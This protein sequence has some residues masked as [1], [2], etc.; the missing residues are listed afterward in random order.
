[1]SSRNVAITSSKATLR[2]SSP[3]NT[4]PDGRRILSASTDGTVRLWDPFGEKELKR[5]RVAGDDS[6]LRALSWSEDG[7][8]FLVGSDGLDARMSLYN[9]EPGEELRSYET[10]KHPTKAVLLMDNATRAVSAGNSMLHVWDAK[11]EKEVRKFGAGVE[12]AAFT[13]D[14]RLALT[15]NADHSVSVWD[16]EQKSSL[17]Q[18]TGHTA[19][20][21]SLAISA[22]G[23]LG[24]SADEEGSIRLW[25]LP[26]AAGLVHVFEAHR[27]GIQSVAFAPDGI[28]A[29]SAGL[30]AVAQIMRIDE[31]ELGPSLSLQDRISSICFSADSRGVLYGTDQAKSQSNRIAVRMIDGGS[32]AVLDRDV[33]TFRGMK[34][35]VSCAVYSPD[36]LLVAGGSGDGTLRVWEVESQREIAQLDSKSFLGSS[37]SI[38]ALA[39]RANKQP[40]ILWA[41]NDNQF[42]QW[43]YE[44]TDLGPSKAAPKPFAGHTGPVNSVQFSPSGRFAI[45]ASSDKS[46]RIWDVESVQVRRLFLGHTAAVSNVAVS[47]DGRFVLSRKRRPNGPQMGLRNRVSLC[48]PTGGT[49]APC[50]RWPFRPTIN[51]GF[52]EATIGASGFGTSSEQHFPSTDISSNF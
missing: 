45:S 14:A 48:S 24:V 8:K 18:F 17:H 6:N 47:S 34:D 1:M 46:V 32:G 22:D 41:T 16:V 35:R 19:R 52:P 12:A 28:H 36:G 25:N 9:V 50:A 39:F 3:F 26:V 21:T 37:K 38:N 10:A 49:P 23:R 40:L 13:P 27:G 5:I 43:A 20:I 11:R 51:S 4:R 29:V 2:R 30:D 42:Y 44:K 33:T 15:A 31:P 7:T